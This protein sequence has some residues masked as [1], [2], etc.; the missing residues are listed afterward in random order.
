MRV[1]ASCGFVAG[2]RSKY[3][4]RYSDS[5]YRYIFSTPSGGR[6]EYRHRQTEAWQRL[7]G[8]SGQEASNADRCRP[9]TRSNSPTI[10][11]DDDQRA[12]ARV[13]ED[14]ECRPRQSLDLRARASHEYRLHDEA[15]ASGR[16]AILRGWLIAC[17]KVDAR[18]IKKPSQTAFDG[19]ITRRL[20][21][22]TM[23]TSLTLSGNARLLASVRLARGSIERV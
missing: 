16:F 8:V 19:T 9:G 15:A 5:L 3:L 12:A 21:S 23:L 2:G 10:T 18:A 14:P 7:K 1:Q 4:F 6:N 20:P 11:G 22:R 17:G 13:A